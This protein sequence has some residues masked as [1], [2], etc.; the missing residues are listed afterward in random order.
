MREDN[1]LWELN[2]AIIINPWYVIDFS[3]ASNE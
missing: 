1:I 3:G 2:A